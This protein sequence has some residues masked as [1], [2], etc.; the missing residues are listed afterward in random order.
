[1][2]YHKAELIPYSIEWAKKAF[3]EFPFAIFAL[4]VC[5]VFLPSCEKG[6]LTTFSGKVRDKVTG[7]P[8][9][10]AMFSVFITEYGDTRTTYPGQDSD[11][12]FT[13]KEGKFMLN[14]WETDK[15][16]ASPCCVSKAGY[17]P[18]HSFPDSQT[19]ENQYDNIILTPLDGALKLTFLNEKGVVKSLSLV[20]FNQ[21]YVDKPFF[22]GIFVPSKAPLKLL[23]AQSFIDTIQMPAGTFVHLY[24]GE[25]WSGGYT[26]APFKDSVFVKRNEITEY[27]IYY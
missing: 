10:K 27:S 15:R 1:M 23:Q 9:E 22:N 18:K 6:K 2:N 19:G 8:V 14:F 13:D 3:A 21:L 17:R 7:E 12:T 16:H 5:Y 4:L 24:W 25:S 11:F 26:N 20:A